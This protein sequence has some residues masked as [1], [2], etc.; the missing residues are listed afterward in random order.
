[1]L[2]KAMKKLVDNHQVISFDVYDTL[3]KRN[4]ENPNDVFSLIEVEYNKD[5]SEKITGFQQARLLA[6]N[7]AYQHHKASCTI[8]D[9]YN[10]LT[11]YSKEIR[12]RLKRLECWIE[13]N[14]CVSNSQMMDVYE[15]ARMSNKKIILV[16]DMYFSA[17][18]I[19]EI[20]MA[21]GITGYS[22]LF[23][24]CE[25]GASKIDGRLFDIVKRSVGCKC[26]DILHIGDGWKND[27]MRTAVK[28]IRP[29]LVRNQSKLCYNNASGLQGID[30]LEYTLQ[31]KFIDNNLD[32]LSGQVEK[33]GFEVFGPLIYGFCKWLH[34]LFHV[35]GIE[36]VFFL[37]R[38]GYLF[39]A[40]YEKMYPD[41]TIP[42]N[43]LYVSR[44]SLLAP[45]YWI[46]D[47]YE[48]IVKSVAKT[49][50]VT[51][52]NIIARWGLDPIIYKDAVHEVGLELEV[53]IDGHALIENTQLQ[54]LYYR[55][56]D[57]IVSNSKIK[58]D[59]LERYLKQYDFG[60]K[61]AVI[62][63]GWNGGMQ[64]AF[65]KIASVWSKPTEI[66]GYYMGINTANLGVDLDNTYGYVYQNGRDDDERYAI[67]SFAGP[68]E[69]SLTALHDTTVGYVEENGLIVPQFG[70]G[71]YIR[72]D[73][74]FTK[75]LEYTKNVQYGI[76]KY[77]ELYGKLDYAR[78]LPGSSTVAFRNCRLFGLFPSMKHIR[79]FS[80]FH[81]NN[82]GEEQ[83]FVN[84]KYRH[85]FGKNSIL[86]G[87]WSSTWKS[88]FMK[89]VFRLPLPYYRLYSY[90]RRRIN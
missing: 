54:K 15:Y 67:Y 76:M 11:C 46:S 12:G 43:Y 9:I 88:G 77:A 33:F 81:S 75:E 83:H 47:D 29:Y 39:K 69:L 89:M 38:E 30:A 48:S 25:Y 52:S 23:V 17:N 7:Q 90:L 16:S 5:S 18:F 57:D 10:E 37:A 87:F 59:F 68:F 55:L 78:N 60:G 40:V 79:F 64:N 74:T 80:D 34:G 66:F 84:P 24:S 45:T 22:E 27:F 32:T 2:T 49:K 35:R 6:Y 14:I 26:E 62:D 41:E 19:R 1:M 8:D 50:S 86:N 70:S 42:L 56:K 21:C 71:E 65:C 61:V 13:S 72:A 63:V 51:V 44:K 3:I 31:Q 53:A 28:G 4:V 85:L 58:Y 73:G 36:K 20:L 82:L